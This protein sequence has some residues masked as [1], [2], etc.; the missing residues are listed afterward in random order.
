MGLRFRKSIT[1][2]PGVKLNLGKTGASLSVG[3]K[4]LHASIHTSGKMTTTASLPGTGISYVKTKNVKTLAKDLKNSREKKKQEKAEAAAAEAAALEAAEAEAALPAAEEAAALPA[5]EAAAAV[6]VAAAAVAAA[7]EE[8]PAAPAPAPAPA[9]AEAAPAEFRPA[10]LTEEALRGI[11]KYFDDTVD[12][13]EVSQ[14]AT[15]PDSSYNAEMW[16]YYH[17]KAPAVMDGDIDTY[18]QVIAEVCPLNDLLDYGGE[19]EFGTD[20]ASLMEVEFKVNEATLETQRLEKNVIQFY[21]LLQDYVCSTCIRI[22]RDMFALLP[23][24]ETVVHAVLGEDTVVSVRFDRATM[25]KIKFGYVDPSEVMDRF[26]HRMSFQ[27][28]RGF[29]PVERIVTG[30]AE[31]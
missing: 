24:S 12:W 28:G 20:R 9:A 7:A 23:V 25:D 8:V 11:H 22:A 1:L 13:V 2:L 17:E 10:Q 18:L 30:A 27:A 3:V 15:P 4:G 14:S 31:E 6:P 5:A 16:A 26:E 21:D 29:E 19:F